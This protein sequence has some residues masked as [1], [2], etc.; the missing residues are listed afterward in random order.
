MA[1]RISRY[2]EPGDP[3]NAETLTDIT[4]CM[5]MEKRLLTLDVEDGAWSIFILYLTGK[6]G[7]EATKDYLNPLVKE[8]TQVLIDEVLR[9]TLCTLQRNVR[10]V[11][12]RFLLRRTEIWK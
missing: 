3:I 9:T 10:N 11:D 6:G 7:E 2:T 1:K 8:A 5:D 4:E 12:R